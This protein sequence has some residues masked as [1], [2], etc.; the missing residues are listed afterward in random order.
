[1][2]LHLPLKERWFRMIQSGEKLEE[3]REI[4]PY[5]MKRLMSCYSEDREEC[6]QCGCARIIEGKPSPQGKPWTCFHISNCDPMLSYNSEC[7]FTLGYP[8]KDD[9]ARHMTRDIE[10]ITVGNPNP[11]WCPPEA[12]GREYFVIKLRKK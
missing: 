3:Y 9:T 12:V 7:H 10:T 4:T 8:K 5:W 6:Q 1:M 2:I 11:A